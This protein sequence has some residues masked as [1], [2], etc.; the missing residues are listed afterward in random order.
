[1]R[2]LIRFNSSA[3]A[4]GDSDLSMYMKQIYHEYYSSPSSLTTGFYLERVSAGLDMGFIYILTTYVMSV[5]ISLSSAV[6]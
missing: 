1:M 3:L 2:V 4:D 5:V 6:V